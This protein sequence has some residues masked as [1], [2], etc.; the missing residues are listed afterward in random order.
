[1]KA[2]IVGLLG[3]VLLVVVLIT[4]AL[5]LGVLDGFSVHAFEETIRGW[6]AWGVLG[7]MGLMIIHSFVPFPAEFLAIANGMVYG[8][9][10]GTAVTWSG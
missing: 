6:G 9:I 1:M 7:S 4:G 5:Y 10:W 3:L 8:P 2:L